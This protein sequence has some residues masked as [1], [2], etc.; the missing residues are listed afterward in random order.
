MDFR[1][2]FFYNY[3]QMLNK[4]LI[5]K[6][7]FHLIL[8]IIDTIIILLKTLN[9]YHS[10]YN[11]Q[12]NE[13]HKEISPSFYFKDY[14]LIKRILPVLIYLIIVYIILIVSILFG[15]NKKITKTDM[16]IINL[17]ELFFNRIII[18]LFFDFLFCL[19]SLYFLLFLFLSLP[20]IIFIF[21]DMT[22]FHL[23][24]FM[25]DSISFP[26]DE[27]TSITDREKLIIKI[28]I[29][30]GSISTDVYIC[31]FIYFL[32]FILLV[33]FGIYNTYIAFYKSYYFMNNELYDKIRYS[34]LLSIII[35]EF[36]AFFMKHDEIFDISFITVFICLYIFITLLFFISY[37]PYNYIIIHY[38]NNPEN[39][40]YYFFLLDRKKNISF[41]LND[42]IK[43]HINECNCCSLCFKYQKFIENNN[44]IE[45]TKDNDNNKT[46]ENEKNETIFHILYNGK[47]KSMIFFNQLIN[48][49]KRLGNNCLNNNS[50]YAIQFNYI[51]FYNLRTGNITFSLNMLLL[52]NLINENN[53][54]LITNDKI[55]INQI[56]HINQFLILYKQIL[57][58]I[59][60]I[61]SKS[62]IKRFVDKFFILA[63]KLTK[64]N[65]KKFKE[66]LFITKIEGVSNYSYM[67]NICSLLYEE[68]FNK[69]ISSHSIPIREN[70]QLV[71][72]IIKNYVKQDNHIILNFNIKTIECK[73]LNSG[74]QL[75]EYINKNFYDLFPNQIKMKLIQNFS[76]EILYPRGKFPKIS[77]NK[78]IKQ[79]SKQCIE[80][81]LVI[82]N[83]EDDNNFLW[84]LHLK[85]FLLF[86]HCI[87]EN[88][89]LSG[90]FIIHKN[91]LMTIKNNEEK[92]R[93]LGFGN[94]DIMNASYKKKLGFQRFLESEFMMNKQCNEALTF[95]LNE[96]KFLM[97]L[98]T[99]NK[100]KRKKNLAKNSL[101]KQFTN[102]KEIGLGRKNTRN[103]S[104]EDIIL[105][106]N[107]SASGNRDEDNSNNDDINNSQKVRNFI[108]DTASQSSSATK[109]TLSS[110]WNKNKPQ[111]KDNQNYFS[112][113][114]FFRFQMFLGGFLFILLILII[115]FILNI[116][117]KQN[118][119]SSDCDNY[120]DLIQF[121]RIFQQFSIEFLTVVCIFISEEEGCKTYISKF[122][123]DEFNQ[124][125]FNIEQSKI[126]AELGSESIN[127]LIQNTESIKDEVLFN[128][129]KGNFTYNLISKKKMNNIY[130]IT[131]SLINI[132][133]NDALLLTSN[134]MRIIV[135]SE[136]RAKNRDLEPIYLL[137]GYLSPFG[138]INNLTDDL[139]D[140]Q[141]A[142]YT[143]LMNFKGTVYRFSMLNQRFHYLINKRNNELLNF[144]YVLHNI[145]FAVMAFQIITILFYLYTYNSVLAE[146]INSLIAKF[147]VIYDNENDFKTMYIH[148][149]NLLESLVNEKNYNLGISINLINKN[150]I[151]Y[152]NLV[153]M[154]KR[155]EQRLNINKKIEK[156]E[157]KTIVFKDNHKYINW[158][159]IYNKGYDRFYI[160]FTLLIAIIDVIIYGAI[161]G[162][163][164][165]YENKSVLTLG[166]ISDSW[167]FE[168][169]TLR[170][171][172]FYHHMIIANQ[173]LDDISN[174]YFDEDN[175][176]CIEHFLIILKEYN[177]LRRKKR[178]AGSIFKSYDD[179]CEHNCLSL[180]NYM[181]SKENSFSTAVKNINIKYGKD[182]NLQKQNFIN[183]CEKINTFVGKSAASIFQ[184]FYQNCIDAMIL[185]S[186]RSYDGLIKKLF[187][188][189]LGM[190]TSIFL[191]VTRYILYIIGN[192]SYT[193]SFKNIVTILG[194]TIITSMILYVVSE[195]FLCIFFFF[196]YIWNINIECKNMFELK[197]VFEITNL[198]DS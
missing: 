137:S 93:I 145:I 189:K 1:Y 127:K 122:D 119:I 142:V 155:N 147:D 40:Y 23:G 118:D 157:E 44:Q 68:I 54:T 17:F 198:N 116:K 80:A 86:N 162:I 107:S 20:Y 14:F 26:F 196:I 154:N 160:I 106:S 113:K 92:E 59:K 144:V 47:D 184:G 5:R 10:N 22:Y 38:A 186:D 133:L 6:K 84:I 146:I 108:E 99:V 52:F 141:I 55:A 129:L 102:F 197:K 12:V 109:S 43:E 173:T 158:I 49:I 4:S 11:T 46:E 8:T 18:I 2:N 110:L 169:I 61:I 72:D 161:L 94:K 87:K 27:Y 192:E 156:E 37:D 15:N 111:S 74:F 191:N 166:L 139:S 195:C 136:S 31:K 168:R 83:N 36:F 90:Y 179:F 115:I 174:D 19:P 45:L 70:S 140:Y 178:E 152:E 13:I 89:L 132:S 21:I 51:Y 188:S 167:D 181:M 34:N 57:C 78:N 123:T 7:E 121:V 25:L 105:K 77:N 35:I 41:Y 164:K 190:V 125:E 60:E 193:G 143:Y 182:I 33:S 9:I 171:I 165:S 100:I 63:K 131:N 117:I 58:Q 124:T 176:T 64:L 114:K 32:Q 151:K 75:I 101:N 96:N 185:F 187:D 56:I 82:K 62:V 88:I 103:G 135:S 29:S 73:I 98:I 128:L 104:M 39:L 134:N 148:K 126:L 170:I 175:Y 69:S 91:T 71:E 172:N 81:S 76:N 120:L 50:Y 183:Q 150:C 180:Y 85:L 65:S 24:K 138:N 79:K 149:I 42:K 194:N 53:Q 28:I 48:N 3:F 66:N 16:V 163:W 159:D 97:Y 177:Q 67:L 153:R 95:T 112:S 30:V 130:N